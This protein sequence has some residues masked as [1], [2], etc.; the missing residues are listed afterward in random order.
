M[1]KLFI[2]FIMLTGAMLLQAQVR[3]TPVQRTTQQSPTVVV[4]EN[5][6]L[7]VNG[8]VA[9]L[10]I[11]VK[12]SQ[13][14]IENKLKEKGLIYKGKDAYKNDL[15]WEGIVYGVK[16][17]VHI[18]KDFDH[19]GSANGVSYR[20][21]KNYS[22]A[23]SRNRVFA[24][25]KAFLEATGGKVVEDD[26]SFNGDEGGLVEIETANNGHIT[27]QYA[28]EDEVNFESPYF[29]VIVIFREN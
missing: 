13:I 28:N 14:N 27:I 19:N 11:P 12:Q 25:R 7:V 26:T 6:P 5:E 21:L 10:G 15:G 22:K 1:K 16:C 4:K 20:E 8:H 17:N 29:N 9:F 23:Q 2:C 18:E 3:R 24:Y